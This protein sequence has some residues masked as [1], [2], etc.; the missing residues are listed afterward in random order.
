MYSEFQLKWNSNDSCM[1][2]TLTKITEIVNGNK[3][4][5][6][7]CIL[8]ADTCTKSKNFIWKYLYSNLKINKDNNIIALPIQY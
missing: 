1:G 4:K 5:H 3:I 7:Y 2:F 8:V 6:Q